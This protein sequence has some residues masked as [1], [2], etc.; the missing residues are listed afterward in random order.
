[1]VAIVHSDQDSLAAW[2]IIQQ[3][4]GGM[5][6]PERIETERLILRRPRAE[7]IEPIFRRY[8]ND[9]DVT[10]WLSWPRHESLEDTRK[11]LEFSD[12]E[13]Q[14]WPAGP[15]LVESRA[16][17]VLLGG[18]GFGFETLYRASTGYVFARDS[19]GKGYATEA[20][21]TAVDVA[22]GI[23]L[24]RLYALCHT[25]HL[26]SQRVL[27]KCCFTREGILRRH[28]ELPNLKRNEPCDVFC[29]SLILK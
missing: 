2:K 9:V 25:D 8:A 6:A 18:A 3:W 23:G 16:D 24:I 7:D 11:F 17:G 1:M 10:H 20:L 15:Y 13:W 5:K 29:Y 12:A 22:R 14:R 19:W 28:S 27:E 26:A 21:Q 4:G